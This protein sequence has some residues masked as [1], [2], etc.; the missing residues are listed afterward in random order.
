[1]ANAF[2]GHENNKKFRQSS[3]WM[4]NGSYPFYPMYVCSLHST[5]N[6]NAF[7]SFQLH[8]SWWWWPFELS[9]NTKTSKKKRKTKNNNKRSKCLHFILLYVRNGHRIKMR[10]R[11]F[12]LL[13]VFVV[14]PAFFCTSISVSFAWLAVCVFKGQ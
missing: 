6:F 8:H 13:L 4:F 12:L 11:L 2:A 1:M 10:I 5:F 9:L 14:K 7:V 3:W